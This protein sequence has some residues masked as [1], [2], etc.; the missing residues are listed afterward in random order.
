MTK[1]ILVISN[2]NCFTVQ[3]EKF[4]DKTL[5]DFITDSTTVNKTGKIII[6][7]HNFYTVQK[8][9]PYFFPNCKSEDF[10]KKN[11][12]QYKI[13]SPE[14]HLPNFVTN[15]KIQLSYYDTFK[16]LIKKHIHQKNLTDQQMKFK[17]E[18]P[19]LFMKRNGKFYSSLLPQILKK[20]SI[21]NS[22]KSLKLK[23]ITKP[24]LLPIRRK[25]ST[26]RKF[27]RSLLFQSSQLFT[28]NYEKK[29]TSQKHLTLVRFLG[30]C[31]S[32]SNKSI[33]LYSIT[34][35]YFTQDANSLFCKNTQF[36]E[37]GETL[38]LLKLEKEITGDIVQGL[39]KIEEILEARKK[40]SLRK[41]L[42]TSQK[43]GLLV[44]KSSL[45][46][47]FE[48]KK[49]GINIKE[50]EKINPHK[51]LKVYF[52]YYG[53]RKEFSCDKSLT[54]QSN[55]LIQNY[56]GSYKSLK[57]VQ[58]FI[59]SSV[60]SVYSSQGVTIHDKHLEVIIKQMS[61]KVMITDEKDTSLLQREIIDLYHIQSINKIIKLQ[62]K[63]PA[64]YVPVLLGDYK[65]RFK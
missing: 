49:L 29:R 63:Q 58:S 48:F 24:K 35:D 7:N 46:N 4:K 20:F 31:F 57:K 60:Q 40:N 18:F 54:V 30:N 41:K 43:K 10:I 16:F 47:N 55:R 21:S 13:I 33:G 5:N 59:L 17:I 65:S 51:L 25:N 6:E 53:L 44:Q 64:Y 42:P 8:G 11:N 34:D 52:N 19:K 1:Q 61:T 32:K 2:K 12:F 14:R 45:D 28:N 50:S 37:S 62:K 9:I 3:K 22:F 39:P 56:E 15:Y 23:Q 27:S 36:L 26:K 38:G